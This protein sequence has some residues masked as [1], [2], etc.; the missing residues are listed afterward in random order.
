YTMNINNIS[1]CI[2]R[3]I[4]SVFIP[5]CCSS[6]AYPLPRMVPIAIKNLRTMPQNA[7]TANR[8]K[9]RGMTG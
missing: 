6:T 7:A 1:L 8:Q 4:F 9:L 3:I 5:L 2:N